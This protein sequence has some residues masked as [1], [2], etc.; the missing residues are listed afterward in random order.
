[1]KNS[2]FGGTFGEKIQ[3]LQILAPPLKKKP[4]LPLSKNW[5]AVGGAAD[6][7]WNIPSQGAFIVCKSEFKV[8]NNLSLAH[9]Q[10]IPNIT[11]V[12]RSCSVYSHLGYTIRGQI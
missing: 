6:K 8:A 2:F 10:A 4:E 11:N 1:M 9:R 5:A 12:Q 3:G 7:K